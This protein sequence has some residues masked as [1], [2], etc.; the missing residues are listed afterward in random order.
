MNR[1]NKPLKSTA[2]NIVYSNVGIPLRYCP[3]VRT[4]LSMVAPPSSAVLVVFEV[5]LA[6]I[7]NIDVALQVHGVLPLKT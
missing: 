2:L 5:Y 4:V 6:G 3:R 1:F 7:D